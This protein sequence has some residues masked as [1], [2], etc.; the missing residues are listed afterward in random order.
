MWMNVS[1]IYVDHQM[2]YALILE[3]VINAI[4]LPVHLITS[5]MLNTKGMFMRFNMNNLQVYFIVAARG[6][7]MYV[8]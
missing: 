2:M 3:V 4:Q 6:H 8:I 1:V 7:R 5:K